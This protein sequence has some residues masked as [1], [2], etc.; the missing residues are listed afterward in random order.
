MVMRD[1]RVVFE[2]PQHELE[3][4]QDDYV[5]KFVPKPA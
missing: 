4:Y 1:G 3:A 2:G 5:Q